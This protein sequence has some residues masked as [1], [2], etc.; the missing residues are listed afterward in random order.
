MSILSDPVRL[1]VL[2][3]TFEGIGDGMAI[4]LVRT[5]R[6]SVV[7]TGHDFSTAILT[8]TAELVGQGMCSPIHLGGMGVALESCLDYYDN[9]IYPEDIFVNN[10]PY[11][12]GSHLPDIFLYKP[13]FV[14]D[15]VVAWLCAM[16]HHTDV[17]GRVPGGNACDSTEIYQE[18]IRIPPLKLY[19]RGKINESLFRI[20]EKAVRVPDK[21]LGDLQGQLAALVYGENEYR[22]LIERYGVEDLLVYQDELL[23]YTEQV[24]R[25]GIRMLPDGKWS[26]EDFID[27]DGITDELITIHVTVTKEDDRLDVDFE[28]TS[29]QCKGAIQPVFA[30]SKAVVYGV[31]KCVLG[32]MGVNIPNTGG[33]FR[34]VTISAPEG[35]FINPLLPAPVAARALGLYRASQAVYGAFAQMVPDKV[36]ACTGGCDLGVGLAGYDKSKTHWKA[37]VQLEFANEQGVG[38]FSNRDGLDAQTMGGTQNMSNIPIEQL[39]AEQPVKVNEYAF[40]SDSEG[41]GKFRGAMGMVREWECLMDETLIQVR[42][43][44]MKNPPYG[45][46]G[47]KAS[48]P[49]KI[50]VK[51]AGKEEQWPSKFI[52]SLN[53]GDVL[54][55]EWPGG[56]GWGNPLERSPQLVLADVVAEKISIEKAQTTY[57]VVID[58]DTRTVNAQKTTTLRNRM[59]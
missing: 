18:G 41:S 24:T 19:E 52:T 44:R 55:I 35:T 32:A 47:G 17:G 4:T 38:G 49:T 1:E 21:V 29:R 7:R 36:M 59:N 40:L 10:D 25:Q 22:K 20:I 9:R 50:M 13:V 42:A 57:G 39:E 14:G 43:D 2:K 28:G 45:L 51:S 26:F 37:W 31:M 48:L 6:S 56:G 58:Q 23:D 54:R 30:T 46:H 12:G 8:P 27:D 11:E 34:P 15:R 5:S 16:S 53:K 3:N 33:Y